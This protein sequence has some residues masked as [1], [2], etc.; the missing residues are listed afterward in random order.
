ML[1]KQSWRII[2]N[3][4]SLLFKILR[5]KY[6]KDGNFLEAPIGNASS[7]TWRSICWGRDLFLK[8][9][10]WRVGNENLITIDKDPWINRTVSLSPLVTVDF[11]NGQRVNRLLDEN[12]NWK[13]EL[14]IQS[15]SPQDVEDIMNIPTG[16]KSS[17]D[18][19]IWRYDKKGVFSVKSAYHLAVESN[20]SNQASPSNA[21]TAS[22]L[23]KSI[24]NAKVLPRT[25]ICTWKIVKDIIP[26]KANILK[27]GVSLNPLCKFCQKH[28]E[29]TSHLIWECKFSKKVWLN[30]IPNS[31]NLFSLCRVDWKP[32]EY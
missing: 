7:M 15:F 29:T 24:W 22:R 13:K 8:G 1:A 20:S 17:R 6:F 32:I 12:N 25:K 27:R 26:S 19:I 21:E 9:Y 31:L 14:L 23:W 10:R 5:G 11:L 18:E 30:L 3:P 28:L 4:D 2:K 16:E